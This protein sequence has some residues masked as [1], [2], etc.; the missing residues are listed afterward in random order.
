VVTEHRRWDTHGPWTSTLA[1]LW[2]PAPSVAGPRAVTRIAAYARQVPV[3]LAR[4]F[5]RPLRARS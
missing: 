2:D 5:T 3:R 4:G 1:T